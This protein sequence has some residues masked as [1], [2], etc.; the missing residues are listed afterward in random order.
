MT[1][2]YSS[3]D[4]IIFSFLNGDI[5]LEE[6]NILKDWL[7]SDPSKKEYFK[8]VYKIW[9]TVDLLNEDKNKIEKILQKVN[10]QIG[11]IDT[12]TEKKLS[13]PKKIMLSIAK[14]AAVI[15]ISLCT[16]AFLFYLMVKAPVL[17]SQQTFNNEIIVPFGSKSKIH[18]YDGTEVTLNAG[19][20]LTYNTDYGKDFREVNLVGEG[21][22]KVAKQIDK[23]FIVHTYKA[24][25]KALGTEFNVKA[26]PDENIVET[27]LVKGSIEVN[28]IDS[29]VNSTDLKRSKGVIL[30][31][32]Q[33]VQIFNTSENTKQKANQNP[34]NITSVEKIEPIRNDAKIRLE[35]S[36]PQIETSWKDNR[37]IIQAKD[38]HELSVL[39]SRRYNVNIHLQ[40]PEL[41]KYKFSGTIENETIEQVFNIIQLT[42]PISYTIE[43]GEVTW[44]INRNLEK[45]YKEAY[46]NN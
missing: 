9:N 13:A 3:I 39:L 37:W 6:K 16:G 2:N 42:V 8:E 10:Y 5:S 17:T 11:K 40:N 4:K 32:G 43:K 41:V 23:P 7:A 15:L 45:I 24:S 27:I 35:T 30:K 19:S 12:F 28:E 14:R 25:I 18:L 22:F 29:S 36:N 33:K 21:Y 38:L 26:Y 20:T 46:Q 1:E 44:L 34:V 31:P